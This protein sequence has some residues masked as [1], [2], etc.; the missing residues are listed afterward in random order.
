MNGSTDA[1]EA[2]RIEALRD[3]WERFDNTGEESLILDSLADD[4]R[5]LP[6]G[7]EPIGGKSAVEEFLKSFPVD[8]YDVEHRAEDLFLSGDL[9]VDYVSVEG[10]EVDDEGERTDEVSLKG[11]DVY[12]REA[13][14]NWQMVLSIW[15]DQA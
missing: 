13:D 12:R 14:G 2:P 3:R 6:P 10:S 4:V 5:F 8:A 9:A 15:N 7:G 11:V 1:P